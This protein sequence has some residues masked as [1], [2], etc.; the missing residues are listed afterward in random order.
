[1]IKLENYIPKLF[2]FLQE[3]LLKGILK[4]ILKNISFQPPQP[5]FIIKI[6]LPKAY[7]PY[8][9]FGG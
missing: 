9:Q 2:L 1:M 8:N 6:S 3:I 4:K 7:Q 5:P